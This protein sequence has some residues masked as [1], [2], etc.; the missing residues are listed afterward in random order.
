[1]AVL[2]AL[3]ASPAASQYAGETII[4]DGNGARPAGSTSDVFVPQPLPVVPGAGNPARATM[5]FNTSR[6]PVMAGQNTSLPPRRFSKQDRIVLRPPSGSG[7]PAAAP[8]RTATPSPAPAPAPQ[9]ARA[10]PSPRAEPPQP[11]PASEPIRVVPKPEP[12]PAEAVARVEPA[13]PAPVPPAPARV[14]R[15]ASE[16]T[17]PAAVQQPA[18]EPAAPVAT[19]APASPAPRVAAVTPQAAAPDVTRILFDGPETDVSASGL[20]TLQSIAE[21]AKGDRSMRIQVEAYADSDTETDVWKRRVSLRRA[22]NVRRVLLDSGIESFRILVRALGAPTK[23]GPGNRVDV[24]I[25]TR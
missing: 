4:I 6:G 2:G 11:V 24:K 9:T 21:S 15:P 14:E 25:A 19:P 10:A 20:A 22:Q 16:I 7:R 13:A 18:P 12:K 8:Q 3:L 23:G 5:P 1:M 17:P